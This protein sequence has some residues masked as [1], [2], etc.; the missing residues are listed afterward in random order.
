LIKY[1]HEFLCLTYSIGR[2]SNEVLKISIFEILC[3]LVL[4]KNILILFQL[5]FSTSSS[6]FFYLFISVI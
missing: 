3:K 1:P 6:F 5:G 2:I 4:V